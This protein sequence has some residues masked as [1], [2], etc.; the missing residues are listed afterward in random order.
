MDRKATEVGVRIAVRNQDPG[1]ST[2]THH[3]GLRLDPSA[4]PAQETGKGREERKISRP[5]PLVRPA[6]LVDE[7][8]G[9]SV[10]SQARG[11]GKPTPVHAP[12]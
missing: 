1:C 3:F 12:Q 8:D 5:P 2:V 9:R 6:A 11:E 7:T 10:E 4:C